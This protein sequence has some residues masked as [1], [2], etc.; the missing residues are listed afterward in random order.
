MTK[1][2]IHPAAEAYRL[3]TEEEIAG[4]AEDIA[5][6]GLRD[7][8]V[9]GRINGAKTEL[10]VDGRNRLQACE[11]V[12]IEPQFQTWDFVDD[13]Q[14]RAFVKS[15]S[16]RRDIS[17]GQRAMGVALLYPEPEKGG[18]G[19]QTVLKRDGFSKQ[20][21]SDARADL[22][23]T[24]DLAIAV[25]DGARKLD[26]AL[27]EVTV[28]RQRLETD[29]A[30]LARLRAHAPDLADLVDEERMTLSEAFGAF[31]QRQRDEIKIEESRRETMTRV[32]EES[33]RGVMSFANA[34][35]VADIHARVDSDR[36]FRRSLTQRM[37]LNFGPIDD[38]RAGA[39]ALAVLVGKLADAEDKE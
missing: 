9:M 14:V 20:R 38:I 5:Q 11:L 1:I 29:D 24:R 37:R 2:T 34:E 31:E 27:A 4:L 33:Y 23:Y 26:E 30:Q 13:D 39:Q 17:K 6:H 18:H 7:A 16:E 28:A 19:K 32:A 3:M 10:L 35:F 12:G 21:L 36:N 22:A 15:R 25:R 8:I